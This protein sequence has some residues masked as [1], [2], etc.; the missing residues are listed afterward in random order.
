MNRLTSARLAGLTVLVTLTGSALLFL[1]VG[2]TEAPPEHATAD[3][4]PEDT[5]IEPDLRLGTATITDFDSQGRLKFRLQAR[6]MTRFESDDITHLDT[7]ELLTD[8][9][10]GKPW[11]VAADHGTIH[12]ATDLASGVDTVVELRDNVVLRQLDTLTERPVV[13][14]RSAAIDFHT[15]RQFA[16]S[17][18]SVMIDS[19]VGRTQAAGMEGDL[20]TGM[21]LLSSTT[22]QSVHTI[23]LP[24]Q[25]KSSK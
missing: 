6:Q 25:F 3:P 21:L 7:P 1:K 23:L 17:L 22:D 18:A 15:E 11:K 4:R 8:A 2:K 24:T 20:K 13:V 19:D 16:K 9:T 5:A 12:Q 10:D 14:I